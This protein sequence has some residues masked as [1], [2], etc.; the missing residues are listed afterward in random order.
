V[1]VRNIS[2]NY[3]VF[4][5]LRRAYDRNIIAKYRRKSPDKKKSNYQFGVSRK[6]NTDA[7]IE[8][9]LVLIA[10]CARIIVPHLISRV[11]T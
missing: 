9:Q 3:S 2:C 8:S 7:F 10:K 11:D 6:N 4:L 1:Q 5:R